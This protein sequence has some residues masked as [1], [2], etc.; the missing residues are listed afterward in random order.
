LPLTGIRVLEFSHTVMGP[1]CGVILADLGADVVKVEPPDGEPTRRSAG[2]A[3]GFFPYFNRNK[4]GITADVK[5]EDGLAQIR[6]LVADADVLIENYAPG[7]M[8]RLH[9]DYAAL[10]ALNPRLIYCSLKG[11]LAGPYEQRPALDEIVQYMTGLAYM[12]GP[13][14]RP[15][16][17]GA[18]VVDILG[19]AFGVIGILAAI[20][21]RRRTGRGQLVKSALFES[22]VFL[23]GQ[24]MA[25][26]AVVGE[27]ALPMPARGAAWGIY[28][29]FPA[30]DAGVFIGVTSDKHWQR[31]CEAFGLDDLLADATLRDNAGRVAAKDRI[32]ARVTPI[33]AGLSA[34]DVCAAL[35]RA[36]IPYAPVAT[37]SDLFE[38]PHLNAGLGMMNTQFANGGYAK[39]PRLPLEMGE[40]ALGLR[41][42]PPLLGEHN[43]EVLAEWTAGATADPRR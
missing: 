14:G 33:V 10:S 13:P 30:A 34:A 35:E 2:F 37:P 17:A 39:L 9:L 29:V 26:E 43:A 12:T 16:R 21:E 38:D 19:G 8:E 23:V 18:S 31:F 1:A 27:P 24:H 25:G 7:T 42:Q 5:T 15:L 28:E 22:S 41:L 3:S 20:E 36:Q 6:A 4:R 11:F 40:H 32:K